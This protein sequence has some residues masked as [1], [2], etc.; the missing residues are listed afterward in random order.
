LGFG[1]RDQ[2]IYVFDVAFYTDK[3]DLWTRFCSYTNLFDEG[4][5]EDFVE[6]CLERIP[7]DQLFI[8][9]ERCTIIS[10]EKKLQ[11]AIANRQSPETQDLG[12]TS[13]EK[14]FISAS[15][16]NNAVLAAKL[17]AAAKLIL[18]QERFAKNNNPHTVEV[19]NLWLSY[20]YRWTLMDLSQSSDDPDK[21][22]AKANDVQMPFEL[23]ISTPHQSNLTLRKEC[24]QFKRY[25]TAAA[26]L[27]SDP[28]KCARI[29]EA[30]YKASGDIGHGFLLF[31]CCMNLCKRRKISKDF[32]LPCHGFKQCH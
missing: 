14:S 1:S 5:Y 22:A 30:L 8:L 26:Y 28:E 3:Y 19:R 4:L 9:L 18:A 23:G 15:N 16:S 2:G 24:D 17:I 13:L 11:D 25:I 7:L 27:E 31:K 32:D 6:K 10:R 20:E 12:L 21:F 29:M